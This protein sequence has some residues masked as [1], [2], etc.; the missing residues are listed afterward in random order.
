MDLSYFKPKQSFIDEKS[1]SKFSLLSENFENLKVVNLINK[2][3][4]DYKTN[5]KD[6]KGNKSE[7]LS[8]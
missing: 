7:H 1:S 6:Y 5:I 4:N 2:D 8:F 3:P